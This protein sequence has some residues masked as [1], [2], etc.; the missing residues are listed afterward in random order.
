MNDKQ[1]RESRRDFLKKAAYTAPVILTMSAAPAFARN[2]SPLLRSSGNNGIGQ[3]KRGIIDGP[4][5]GLA[6][7]TNLD[8]NDNGL[9]P[10]LGRSGAQ[11]GRRPK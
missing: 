10:G 4:P 8:F 2:G 1:Y 3:E 7:N 11:A 5:P 9:P 6:K